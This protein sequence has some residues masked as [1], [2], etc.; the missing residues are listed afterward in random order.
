MVTSKNRKSALENIDLRKAV[1]KFA[2]END[3][4]AI[5]LRAEQKSLEEVFKNLTK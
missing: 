5:T 2:Q 4:L 3:I 1:A